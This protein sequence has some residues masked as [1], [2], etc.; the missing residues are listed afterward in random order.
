MTGKHLSWGIF[1]NEDSSTGTFLWILLS[2]TEHLIA[3]HMWR[4][5]SF[6][7]PQV[8]HSSLYEELQ[9]IKDKQFSNYVNVKDIVRSFSMF[10]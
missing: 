5:V 1:L 9:D 8:L 2:F 4:A 7:F 10:H 3:E 6:V